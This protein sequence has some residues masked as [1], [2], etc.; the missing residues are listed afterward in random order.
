[1]ATLTAPTKQ[2]ALQC[3]SLALALVPNSYLTSIMASIDLAINTLQGL[4][5]L[6]EAQLLSLFGISKALQAQKAAILNLISSYSSQL[7]IIDM[8]IVNQCP[9][10]GQVNQIAAE[11]T[12]QFMGPLYAIINQVDCLNRIYLEYQQ[13]KAF[14]Q[15]QIDMLKLVKNAIQN[16]LN[17]RAAVVLAANI[18]PGKIL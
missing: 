18:S 4:M 9:A 12:Q 13:R 14:I 5:A 17:L 2:Q 11:A 8:S 6:L 15:A 7:N 10:L 1:M 3:V 16:M